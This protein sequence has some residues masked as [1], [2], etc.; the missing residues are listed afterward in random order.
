MKTN[1]QLF[2]AKLQVNFHTSTDHFLFLISIIQKQHRKVA[3]HYTTSR[4]NSFVQMMPRIIL[5]KKD[6]A[7]KST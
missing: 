7:R 4:R 3:D 2:A 5:F 6:K 1:S